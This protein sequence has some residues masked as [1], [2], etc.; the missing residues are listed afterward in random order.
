MN[1]IRIKHDGDLGRQEEP[2]YSAEASE[3]RFRNMHA[4]EVDLSDLA[5]CK[6]LAS[7]D[8]SRNALETIDLTPLSNC[9]MLERIIA[10]E[11][12][13][14]LL[15]LWPLAE[16][17]LLKHVDLTL[18]RTLRSLDVTPVIGRALLSLDAS[19][20]LTA[21][22]ILIWLLTRKDLEDM[23]FLVRTD[24]VG[25]SGFPVIIWRGYESFAGEKWYVTRHRIESVLARTSRGNWFSAQRGMMVGLGMGELSGYDG[26]P[27][28]LFKGTKNEMSY[29][30]AVGEIHERALQLLESQVAGGGSTLFLDTELMRKTGASRLIP[31]LVES[32]KREI[33]EIRIPLRASRVYLRG[34][35]LTHY[36][37]QVL[38]AL[39]LGLRTDLE[40]LNRLET[41]FNE[42]GFEL[43]TTENPA[44]R[45]RSSVSASDSLQ[46]HVYHLALG[47][48]DTR[49]P[50]IRF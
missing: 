31:A 23:V 1:S 4:K 25:W 36:G 18:N 50:M 15:D 21:D 8:L 45:P 47:H 11:N 12:R 3:I 7:L 43:R 34:L 14:E 10:R 2:E 33:D 41:C 42:L 48:Y 37:F 9:P 5:E 6:N 39:G 13:I 35:W 28:E 17:S 19:V 27:R 32:R 38:S 29:A 24:R 22:S 20:V 44:V 49:Q 46:K 16:N 40:G 30:E 26:D